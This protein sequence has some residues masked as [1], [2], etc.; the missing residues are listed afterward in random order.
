M[1]RNN[2]NL[3]QA[4]PLT[5]RKVYRLSNPPSLQHCRPTS[6]QLH[7]IFR[8]DSY[9]HC[10]FAFPSCFLAFLTKTSLVT[11]DVISNVTSKYV[12]YSLYIRF[13]L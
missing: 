11:S 6:M 12:N 2:Y 5:N 1:N 7:F 9:R 13:A 4:M 3:D 10:I 8:R